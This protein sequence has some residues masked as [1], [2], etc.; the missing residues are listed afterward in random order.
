MLMTYIM[1][2]DA[3]FFVPDG[4]EMLIASAS[5]LRSLLAYGILI[6]AMANDTMGP[7]SAL[8]ETSVVFAALIGRLFLREDLS[9]CWIAACLMVAAGAILIGHASRRSTCHIGLIVN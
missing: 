5:G 3:N 1:L 6:V 9:R 7:V 4:K 2:R 8:R